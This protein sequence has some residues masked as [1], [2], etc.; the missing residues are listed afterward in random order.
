[1]NQ[2]DLVIMHPDTFKSLKLKRDKD[3]HLDHESMGFFYKGLAIRVDNHIDR[4]IETGRYVLPSGKIVEK[5]SVRIDFKFYY[6]GVEDLEELIL[7]KLVKKE[8]RE[9]IILFSPPSML[10]PLKFPSI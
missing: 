6:L 4:F 5:H 9:N 7:R 10:N 2:R 3:L 8:L 1:M